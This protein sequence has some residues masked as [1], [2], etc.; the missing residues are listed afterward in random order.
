MASQHEIREQVTQKIVAALEK[1]LMPWRQ[2][3]TSYS[4][5]QHHNALTGLPY[6]GINV[7]LLWLHAVEHGFHSTTWATFNQWRKLGCRVNRRP[8]G[9]EPGK[10]G[11][12]LT[13]YVPGRLHHKSLAEKDFF[14]IGL[15]PTGG[16][17]FVLDAD[18]EA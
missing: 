14:E 1:N 5:C 18:V 9:V 12:T 13:V 10:W 6:R 11:A 17:A 7:L 3:W 8:N 16:K 4:S 15:I 2:T